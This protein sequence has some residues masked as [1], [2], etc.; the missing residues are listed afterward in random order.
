MHGP[1]G[2]T[3][4]MPSSFQFFFGI[5][6][7]LVIGVFGYIIFNGLHTWVRNNQSEVLSR[8]CRVVTKRTK[9]WGGVGDS[10]ANTSYYITFE[11]EDL[12][13]LELP[14]R[15]DRYGLIAEG[16]VGVLTYQGTRFLDFERT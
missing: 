8:P 4:V 14:V 10:S 9:V 1:T 15:G 16:D 7:V 6:F 11:F 12:S 5:M 3:D 13:R 2:I